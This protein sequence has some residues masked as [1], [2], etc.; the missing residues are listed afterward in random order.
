M[1]GQ[2]TGVLASTRVFP[3]DQMPVTKTANNG[4]MR[5]V[6]HGA[7]ATGEV[8]AM[9]ETVQPQGAA[10]SPAHR[11]EHSELIVVQQGTVEFTHEGTPERVE[12]GSVIYVAYGTLHSLRNVGD[13]PAKYVVVQIGG[14]TKK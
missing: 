2:G 6:L 9:H 3:L 12:A 4:E 11:I 10:P 8:V 7:L 14:D 1:S 5:S 13:G